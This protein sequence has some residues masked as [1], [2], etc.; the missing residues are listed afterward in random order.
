MSPN[1]R[2]CSCHLR[3]NN[4]RVFTYKNLAKTTP[5]LTDVSTGNGKIGATSRGPSQ[6]R[7]FMAPPSTATPTQRPA[8]G[9]GHT[10]LLLCAHHPR[11]RGEVAGA[12]APRGLAASAP[13]PQWEFQNVERRCIRR[14]GRP[15]QRHVASRRTS[16][17]PTQVHLPAELSL[18]NQQVCKTSTPRSFLHNSLVTRSQG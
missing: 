17:P 15:N 18:P 6:T 14:K 11:G 8:Q 12:N 5:G 2:P 16:T 13:A 4:K 3:T 9:D 10:G 1:N 7:A